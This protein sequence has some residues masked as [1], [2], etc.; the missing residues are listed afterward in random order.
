M[1]KAAYLY[2][3]ALNTYKTQKQVVSSQSIHRPLHYCAYIIVSYEADWYV[4]TDF[5][6]PLYI[7]HDLK[8]GKAAYLYVIALDLNTH[9][10]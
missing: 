9:K 1:G 2:V 10:T 3:I 7:L 8:A 5:Y 4:E 6:V